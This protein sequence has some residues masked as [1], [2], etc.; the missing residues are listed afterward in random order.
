LLRVVGN[1]RVPVDD[2]VIG[3]RWRQPS[4]RQIEAIRESIRENGLLAAIGIRL[5]AE[6]PSMG[7]INQAARVLVYGA[8]RL[9]AAKLEG[10]AEI[11]AQILEGS[12]VDFEKAELAENLHRGELTKLQRDR[13]IARYIELC[14]REGFLRGPRAKSKRG[15]PEGGTRAVARELSIPE[16][17][18]RDAVKAGKLAVPAVTVITELGLADNPAVYRAVAA[19]P[20]AEAQ[21][22]KARELG[23]RSGKK[24]SSC[25]SR[26]HDLR[27]A[28]LMAAWKE[29]EGTVQR[30]FLVRIGHV[31]RR[32]AGLTT[33]TGSSTSSK[34][35]PAPI[36]EQQLEMD[37]VRRNGLRADPRSPGSG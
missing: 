33:S 28:V 32:P 29:A 21:I 7:E 35:S 3:D 19:E 30:E 4:P 17:T 24:P 26:D 12:D 10:W 14:G 36:E 1:A 6:K 37:W 9:A 23:D 8:T 27:L 2:I 15:R 16:S 5:V 18:A 25:T 22:A 11:D 31:T 20:T 34:R 13:Q